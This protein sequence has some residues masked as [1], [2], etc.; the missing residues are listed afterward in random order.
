MAAVPS[1][2]AEIAFFYPGKDDAM[3]LMHRRTCHT[4]VSTLKRMH[5]TKGV[6]RLEQLS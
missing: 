1:G 6:N 2:C 5:E 3:K 4:S